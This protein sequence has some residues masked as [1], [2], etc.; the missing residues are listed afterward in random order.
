M[1]ALVVVNPFEVITDDDGTPLEDGYVYIGTVNLNPESNPV[2]AYWDQALTVTAAQPIRTLNGYYSQDGSP[3]KL[4]ID[5]TDYSITVK[6][7]NQVLLHTSLINSNIASTLPSTNITGQFDADKIDFTQNGTGATLRDV[8]LKLNDFISVKDFG[9]VGDDSNN[10]TTAIQA[11][12]DSISA[13]TIYFP[14]GTYKVTS[15]INVSTTKIT[16]KG[17]GSQASILKADAAFSGT[18]VLNMSAPTG[19]VVEDLQ[20]DGNSNN[21]TGLTINDG[22]GIEINRVLVK[23][24][25]TG[26]KIRNVD[27]CVFNACGSDTMSSGA[28]FNFLATAALDA[29][30][31]I[32]GIRCKLIDCYSSAAPKAIQSDQVNTSSI[33]LLVER[34]NEISATGSASVGTIAV[35]TNH[36]VKLVDCIWLGTIPGIAIVNQETSVIRTDGIIIT[37]A[38]TPVLNVSAVLQG[39]NYVGLVVIQASATEFH[40]AS[41]HSG[42][43]YVL[44]V[45]SRGSGSPVGVVAI[46]S[47]GQIAGSTASDPSF[48]W[49]LDEPN[50]H[51]EATP[52]ASTTGTFFFYITQL[53]GIKLTN[54]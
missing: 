44:L 20:M 42:A 51:L 14:A 10:D 39:D 24:S 30:A 29:A 43:S 22:I 27:D 16:L 2:Q 32:D 50:G 41:S 37:G 7:K 21:V 13:G 53:G 8:D 40:D 15:T 26:Y 31:T 25:E 18:N 6:N 52:I 12:I 49:A 48:T 47:D 38:A 33:D 9:A 36:V 54:V 19:C 23:N 35:H 4:Y 46:A 34:F 3:G 17:E 1:S 5:G 11:A 28:S 45:T